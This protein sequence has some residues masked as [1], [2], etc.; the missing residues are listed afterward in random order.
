VRTTA[1]AL[2]VP[3]LTCLLLLGSAAW[4]QGT[5]P[6]AVGAPAKPDLAAKKEAA[7]AAR[8]QRLEARLAGLDQKFAAQQA[9][10]EALKK[11][12]QEDLATLK[13][14]G[15]PTPRAGQGAS[16]RARME[17]G[18]RVKQLEQQ[19]AKLELR[20][21]ELTARLAKLQASPGAKGAK[22]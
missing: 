4:A 13:A 17:P 21:A 20:K 19:L 10:H 2:G 15:E 5:P 11:R 7:R 3:V 18:E 6:A 12:L 14:G 22:P 8:I 16:R 1:L 9:A